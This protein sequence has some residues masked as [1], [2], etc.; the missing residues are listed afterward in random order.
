MAKLK[1]PIL[2]LEAHGGLGDGVTF[3]K[4]RGV[5][6]GEKKPELKD[7]HSAGQLSWRTM[8]EKCTLLWHALSEAEKFT[9]ES[10]ARPRHMTGYA[11]WQSQCL[12]PNP[13]IYL[14]LAGG[15]MQGGIVMD[16]NVITDLP[17]PI[18]DQDADTK[19]ARNAAITAA[20][21]TKGARVYHNA[22]QSI[23]TATPTALAFNSERYD[24]DVIHDTVT[25]NSRLTCKTAGKYL[26]IG[27]LTWQANTTGQRGT[28]ILLGG[29][30]QLAYLYVDPVGSG[31]PRAFIATIYSLAV[32][33]YVQLIAT[34]NSGIALTIDVEANISPEFM[35]QRIG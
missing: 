16:S 31:K 33:D 27:N 18:A 14:P 10:L 34:Q 9:W 3:K 12:R 22:A 5:N 17:D 35:M 30:T 13:G 20:L 1:N 15:T 8:F 29:V 24:T 21:F 4:S 19:A 6:I 7:A 28:S 32:N 23:D 2:S 26:I 11:L 25:N